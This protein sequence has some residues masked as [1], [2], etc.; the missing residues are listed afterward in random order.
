VRSLLLAGLVL[1]AC[2]FS[3]IGGS[4]DS[5][6]GA[7]AG[8]DLDDDPSD[9]GTT[10][11]GCSPGDP[12]CTCVGDPGPDGCMHSYGGRFGDGACS[13]SFQCCG[14]DWIAGQDVCGTCSCV[15]DAEVGCGTSGQLCF[16]IFDPVVSEL[17]PEV[18]EN[19][20]GNSWHAGMGCPSLDTLRL[21]DMP[22]W[23]FDGAIHRG[24]LVVDA[25]AVSAVLTLFETMYV[26]Q[27]PVER[28]VRVDA[29]GG[30]D[31]L[32]MAD[33]N[34][35]AFNCREITGGGG[36]SQHSFG[37][38][39]DINPVQNPYVY[40]ST[41]LPENGEA[42]TARNLVRPGMIVRPGPVTRAVDQIGWGWGGDWDQPIDYQHV[43]ASGN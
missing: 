25:D 11:D 34:T 37:S 21:I 24:E 1:S 41:V 35:S 9:A 27:F 31:D 22:H 40:G 16:P 42:F 14:G 23:G 38:A 26:D 33:N 20:I 43:S 17:S 36:L 4:G 6:D 8:A 10:I 3:P 18:R 12:D 2:S 19:M 5:D 30:D 32:S 39:I 29:Y 7:D 15:G 28:M 13:P